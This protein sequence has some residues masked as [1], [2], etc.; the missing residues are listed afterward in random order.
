MSMRNILTAIAIMLLS[1]ATASAET[2]SRDAPMTFA[3]VQ[4]QVQGGD[5]F[6][7][8]NQRPVRPSRY[9]CVVPARESDNRN[10]PYVCRAQE[11]RVGGTC[12]CD[13]VTGTGR[14]D[15]DD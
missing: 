2:L 1:V 15:L 5:S 12:R 13:N 14:L 11:G 4:I 8:T 9:V 3:Q 10:R 6:T 7:R